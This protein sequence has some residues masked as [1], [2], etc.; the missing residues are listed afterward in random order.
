M[1]RNYVVCCSRLLVLFAITLTATTALAFQSIKQ[2]KA[3]ITGRITEPTGDKIQID[4]I[5]A[6]ISGDGSF[7]LNMDVEKPS[8]YTLRYGNEDMIIY[9]EPG[10]SIDISFDAKNISSS[11]RF[12]G[13]LAQINSFLKSKRAIEDC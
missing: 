11:L 10:D 7:Q 12:K 6:E 8:F 5:T 3:R 1:K 13:K 9:L 2:P 4:N